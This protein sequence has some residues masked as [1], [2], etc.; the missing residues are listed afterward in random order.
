MS[1]RFHIVALL[2][3][4]AATF[5]IDVHAGETQ[6][7]DQLLGVSYDTGDIYSVSTDDASMSL[8]AQTGVQSLGS[9]EIAPDGQFYGFTTSDGGTPTLYHFDETTFA[10]TA[11]GPL[12][13]QVVFD[14][15]I[16]FSPSG[17]VYGTNRGAVSTAFLFTID[18][19]DGSTDIVGAI[20]VDGDFRHDVNGMAWREDGVLVG[21]DRETQSLLAINP[22]N[23]VASVIA[24]LDIEMGT[25][26]GMTVIDGVGYFATSGPGSVIPG[27]NEL[28]SFD[29]FTG[30][31]QLIGNF[32]GVIDGIGI[33][34]LAVVPEPAT[35][36]LVLCG[37]VGMLRRRR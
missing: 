18:M 25:V 3:F 29:L 28:Y 8:V 5:S 7:A 32:D 20:D 31:Y 17:T 24:E 14:G 35:M 33:G 4:T 15:S 21:L 34:G 36:L 12:T 1:T 10:P 9:L 26:G 22:A 23:A 19:N 30:D 27:S 6:G 16:V 37:G 13:Q 2:L 11:I